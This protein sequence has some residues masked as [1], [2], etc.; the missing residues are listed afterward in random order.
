M[1]KVKTRIKRKVFK[2]I[3]GLKK[4]KQ[5][6]KNLI[7]IKFSF[8]RKKLNNKAQKVNKKSKN[9]HRLKFNNLN[10][11]LNKRELRITKMKMKIM[12]K[13]KTRSK[14]LQEKVKR[15]HKGKNN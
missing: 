6:L 5:P 11:R 15:M 4:E 2:N 3:L 1:G 9:F 12:K 10:K 13:M 8:S 14:V 7:L